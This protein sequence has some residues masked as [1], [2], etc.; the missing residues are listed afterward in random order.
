MNSALWIGQGLLAVIFLISGIAKSTMS[1]ERMLATGQTG[2]E[3]FP[4]P[5]IRFT[6]ISSCLRSSG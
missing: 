3:A 5:V 2:A 1:K 6:T 4:L